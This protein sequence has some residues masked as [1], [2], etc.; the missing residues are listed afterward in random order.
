MDPSGRTSATSMRI[1]LDPMSIAAMIVLALVAI[2][3]L[4]NCVSA[5]ESGRDLSPHSLG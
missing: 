1:A 3:V 4:T 5:S 2:P